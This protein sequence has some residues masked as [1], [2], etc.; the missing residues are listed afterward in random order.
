MCL[1]VRH[2]EEQVSITALAMERTRTNFPLLACASF[3]ASTPRKPHPLPAPY[4]IV[5]Q[6]L[7]RRGAGVR[8]IN[9]KANLRFHSG[10]G[11]SFRN[12][13]KHDRKAE[14]RDLAHF[15]TL[16]HEQLT[17]CMLP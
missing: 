4:T 14:R 13:R 6:G 5:L 11:S 10:L 3:G 12:R 8:Q 16:M 17:W 2:L 7:T 9:R 1:P 15:F